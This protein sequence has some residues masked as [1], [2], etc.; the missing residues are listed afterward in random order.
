MIEID[1]R[2][3]KRCR[4]AALLIEVINQKHDIRNIKAVIRI[5]IASHEFHHP[6]MGDNSVGAPLSV[7]GNENHLI[8]GAQLAEVGIDLKSRYSIARIH[9]CTVS[10]QGAGRDSYGAVLGVSSYQTIIQ[11]RADYRHLRI[12]ESHRECS[13]L[14]PGL[15]DIDM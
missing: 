7:S 8:N 12:G 3:F 4:R 9:E 10:R 13:R 1:I 5:G 15:D 6:V 2:R 14:I 11:R